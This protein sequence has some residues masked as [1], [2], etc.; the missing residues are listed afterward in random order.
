[1]SMTHG[2]YIGPIEDLRGETAL[3]EMRGNMLMAQFDRHT[4]IMPEGHE[5][6]D[7]GTKVAYGWHKFNKYDW[8]VN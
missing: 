7:P 6:V 8:K 1:M 3:L 5:F 2:E 4:A